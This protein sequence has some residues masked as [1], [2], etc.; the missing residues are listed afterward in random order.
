MHVKVRY[1]E[2]NFNQQ[3]VHI[4]NPSTLILHIAHIAIK[5]GIMSMNVHLLKIM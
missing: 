1:N 2:P 4:M 5:L 3:N